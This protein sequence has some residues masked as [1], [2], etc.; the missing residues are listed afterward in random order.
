MA[1][2]RASASAA[3]AGALL[4]SLRCK[5]GAMSLKRLLPLL[6]LLLDCCMVGCG[7]EIGPFL[8]GSG[9]TVIRGRCT[10][11][12]FELDREEEERRPIGIM[13]LLPLAAPLAAPL[14][15]PPPPL[16]EAKKWAPNLMAHPKHYFALILNFRQAPFHP[17]NL[18]STPTFEQSVAFLSNFKCCNGRVKGYFLINLILA[19][20]KV[21]HWLNPTNMI[22]DDTGTSC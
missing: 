9:S 15:P 13:P 11:R 14:A 5:I 16:P 4:E 19:Q 17:P 8:E 18:Q 22:I 21:V 20:S 2:S 10:P 6:L 1:R 7:P 12:T 3:A